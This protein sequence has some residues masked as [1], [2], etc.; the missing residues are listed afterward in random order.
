M[1]A[2]TALS[3]SV[4]PTLCETPDPRGLG[5]LLAGNAA[6]PLTRCHVRGEII[7]GLARTTV[8]QTYEN[9]RSQAMEAVHIFPLPDRGA[10]VSVV[11][12][13]GEVRVV[14]ECREKKEAEATFAAAREKGHRAALLTQEREDVHTLRVTNLPPNTSVDVEIV[15]E[16]ALEV[17]DGRVQYR[18]PTTIA[19]RYTPGEAL[20]QQGPGVSP[21]TD[22]VMDAS[23]LTPP[24]R[25]SGGTTL[26]LEVVVRGSVRQV[27]S[28]LH[29]VSM[30]LEDGAV[31]VA[32]SQAATLDRDFVLAV[33][34]GDANASGARAW[35]DGT[36]TV[37][38]LEPPSVAMPATLPRDAVFVVDI[39]GSMGGRKMEAA[40]LA[41]KTA[42]HGLMPQDRFLLIAFDDRVELLKRDFMPVTDDALAMA[43]RWVDHL[44]ARGG[45]V[46][47]P[48]LEQ[49]LTLGHTP[50]GRQR[51]V[52]FVTDGQ[53]TDEER[54]MQLLWQRRGEAR[55]FPL[56]IDTA[57]NSALL[58]RMA[59]IGGGV[60][61]LTEP[62]ADIEAVVARLE[63]RFGAPLVEGVAVSGAVPA[64]MP[65]PALFLGRPATVLLEGGASTF[66]VSGTAASGPWTVQVTPQ[67]APFPLGPSWARAR[68]SS[69]ED[70]L[71]VKPF[72]EDALRPEIIRVALAH[73]VASRWTSF[74]AVDTSVQVT[75]E[76]VEVVQPMEL[77][78]DWSPSAVALSA[79]PAL[80]MAGRAAPRRRKSVG[81]RSGAVPTLSAP[82]PPPPGA[83]MMD[84]ALSMP[85]PASA[86]SPRADKAEKKK[87]GGIG[88]MFRRLLSR[89]EA[90]AELEDA[91]APPMVEKLAEVME[92]APTGD[93]GPV[94]FDVDEDEESFG[95]MADSFAAPEPAP[96]PPPALRAAPKMRVP[97]PAP[98]P[99]SSSAPADP[100][101]E[102][103]RSQSADG[104]FGGDLVQTLVALLTLMRAGHTRRAGLRRRVVV[105]AVAWLSGHSADPR[106]MATLA[107]LERVEGG[108]P[109]ADADWRAVAEQLGDSGQRWLAAR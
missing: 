84:R 49:A 82:M 56:G 92:E 1:S 98:R 20:G 60:C 78:A 10:V 104:S 41:L 61:E 42:L 103:A 9:T 2:Q 80:G 5:G 93:V 58:R 44:H 86:P 22:V 107:L 18:F 95:G 109:L 94:G 51:T 25:L 68:V 7:G 55:V 62:R 34:F 79:P 77:P 24:L 72:E 47:A 54:L 16:E 69:L 8:T 29:A 101:G 76:P 74:V 30:S 97:S 70:R 45:T 13:A 39:S 3:V 19:P 81:R 26:D 65:L 75:G 23:R 36:H 64:Q 52:L 91:P 17:V 100:T 90:P 59:R 108:E 21:D 87:G 43:D 38:V 40:K 28:S 96:A 53:S 4:E 14:A 31:R 105:K 106:V 46:M 32:P 12:S 83:P 50:T 37:L 67:K 88:G 85:A 73:G 66:S 6:L 33:V 99:S 48:A 63:A 89:E 71:I 102:L 11:L 57:V 35:T 27:S 15:V